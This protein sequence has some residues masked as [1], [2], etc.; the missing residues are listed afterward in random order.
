M[1]IVLADGTDRRFLGGSARARNARVVQRVGARSHTLDTLPA[2]D[3]TPTVFVPPDSALM[4]ALFSDA[5]FLERA[6]TCTPLWLQAEPGAAVLVG[7][8]S[9]VAALARDAAARASVPR[10]PVSRGTILGIA[11][12]ADRRRAMRTALR[13]TQKPTDGWISRTCNRPISRACSAAALTVGFSATGASVVTLL[14][15]LFTALVAAQPGYVPLVLTGVLFHLASVL[16][17]VD[18]E[19]ARATLT[20][21]DTGARVDTIVDQATYLA[22]FVGLTIGWMREG[23][24]ALATGSTLLVGAA[25]LA[26]L[27]RAGRFVTRH[28]DNASFVFVDRSV[29]RAARE[30]GQWPLRLA[31][32]A[33][34]L[35]RR[36][37]F[38]VLFLLV[39]LAGARVVIPALILAGTLIANL[40]F[41]IYAPELA[42]AA[43]AE[44]AGMKPQPAS[45]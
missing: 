38:A 3:I 12:A 30:T 25:L 7:P 28:A 34:T 27:L 11:S 44:R 40:T 16:D 6:H 15:G 29:R 17:G 18:G 26:T 19:I 37:L 8:A 39:S 13:A 35:L 20:E 4:V 42:D 33:F 43:R 31:A 14:V 24:S 22:C 2:H 41:S 9:A 5:A 1:F 32:R 21:S 10:V 36:D 23:S 45:A